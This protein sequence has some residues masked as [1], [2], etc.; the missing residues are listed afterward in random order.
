MLRVH[1]ATT[2]G[3]LDTIY[4]RTSGEWFLEVEPGNIYGAFEITDSTLLIGNST[5]WDTWWGGDMDWWDW[6]FGFWY[7][8]EEK[9]RAG[10]SCEW[11]PGECFDPDAAR[12]EKARVCGNLTI[13]KQVINMR[14]VADDML[15]RFA[16]IDAE[17]STVADPENDDEYMYHLK[18]GQRYWW[19]GY[20]NYNKGRPH[21]AISDFKIAWKYAIMAQKWAN[22]GS[23][24]AE[25]GDGDFADPCGGCGGTDECGNPEYEPVVKDPWWMWW[26]FND[27]TST[28]LCMYRLEHCG[29]WNCC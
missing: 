2:G 18:W 10:G 28:S 14:V 25:P 19:R 8:E 23:E 3:L 29:N 11:E 26:Y 12:E 15:A 24:D 9:F 5:A 22:K 16:H 6:F 4:L 17:N 27:C 20:D 13:L 7:W 1:H 21:R